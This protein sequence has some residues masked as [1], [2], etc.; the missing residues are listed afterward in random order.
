MTIDRLTA[1][2]TPATLTTTLIPLSELKATRLKRDRA[3]RLDPAL[4]DLKASILGI[5]LSNPIRVAKA[6]NGGYELIEGWR[7]SLAYRAL[8]AETG[9]DRWSHI[10]AHLAPVAESDIELYRRM[11][12][13]N[14]VRKDVSFAEMARLV[15][16][17]VDERVE[18]CEDIDK[19]VDTIFASATRQKRSQIR[20]F[21][22]LMHSLEK[23]LE[24]PEA[25]PRD[26]GVL[27][28]RRLDVE[29]GAVR[30]LVRMLHSHPRRDL[31]T[32]LG[33]LESFTMMFNDEDQAAEKAAKPVRVP[34]PK[35]S[36]KC[37]YN[38][39]DYMVVSAPWQV[40]IVAH[41]NFALESEERLKA[42]V[43][44]FFA[45]LDAP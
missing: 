45:V 8:H 39:D 10:P 40:E 27:V 3:M 31:E 19:A 9:D 14:M 32:E 26:L 7:R 4:D 13:E 36:N 43:L 29:P 38:F 20:Y 15:R 1:R 6:A 37:F 34:R 41:R 17:A 44:A 16:G 28:A 33:I 25:I 35:V 12:D 22:A 11:V 2:A 30:M 23:Y 42:A 5:G 24:H 18:G 21:A